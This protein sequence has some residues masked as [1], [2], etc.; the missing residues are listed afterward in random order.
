[1]I[2]HHGLKLQVVGEGFRGG[3]LNARELQELAILPVWDIVRSKQQLYSGSQG[4]CPA[5]SSVI[6]IIKQYLA[7][8]GHCNP[9]L[10]NET[11]FIEASN[12]QAGRD[13]NESPNSTFLF[14]IWGNTAL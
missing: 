5:M 1:M 6:T 7:R 9:Y 2:H 12:F 4:P 14:Y 11:H 10:F 3:G 8:G 13:L